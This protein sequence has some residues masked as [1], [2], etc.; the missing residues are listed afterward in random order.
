[1]PGLNFGYS[2]DNIG[3]RLT[4]M[5]SAAQTTYTPNS[6]NQYTNITTP[7]EADV[8]VKNIAGQTSDIVTS[9]L[10]FTSAT[11]GSFKNFHITANNLPNGKY[12]TLAF[13]ADFTLQSGNL[14]FPP[15][16]FTPIY[17]L[18]GNL[19]NDGR[20]SYTWDGEN[21]L[22]KLTTLPTA[23]TAGAP[24]TMLDFSYDYQNRRIGKKVTTTTGAATTVKNERFLYD[25][26]NMVADFATLGTV[27][28]LQNKYVWGLDNSGSLQ[29]A[30]G[31]GGLISI[32]GMSPIASH[33]LPGTMRM[34][35]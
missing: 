3:N 1:V 34:E 27:I 24:N 18:D 22:I 30:G 5:R 15:A 26:W 25:G 32:K 8:L 35:M 33:S 9:P 4:A 21:R 28:G 20:F 13:Q 17:D 12:Q 2:Y 14:W 6:V 10:T 7:G 29:G 11:S 16:S 23:V 19:L 31:V